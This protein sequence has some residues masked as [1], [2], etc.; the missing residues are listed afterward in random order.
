M[1]QAQTWDELRG[2]GKTRAY[3]APVLTG[4]DAREI[5]DLYAEGISGAALAE[6]F[7]VHR[8]TISKIVNG[9]IHISETA[10]PRS[11]GLGVP[12]PSM[13]DNLPPKQPGEAHMSY[14]ERINAAWME[15]WQRLDAMREAAFAEQAAT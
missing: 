1:Q 5:R 15:R 12:V 10:M 13:P 7:G 9:H 4:E 3:R 6:I 11:P 14:L 8:D 2:V